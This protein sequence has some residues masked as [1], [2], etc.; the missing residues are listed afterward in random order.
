MSLHELRQPSLKDKHI[1]QAAA[2]AEKKA[3]G[4][5][6]VDEKEKEKT[7]KLKGKK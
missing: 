1:E 6:K 5:E 3:E 7:R 2:E 4:L